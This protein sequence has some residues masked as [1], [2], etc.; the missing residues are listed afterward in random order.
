MMK[1]FEFFLQ[2]RESLENPKENLSS[3]KKLLLIQFLLL[4]SKLLRCKRK[5]LFIKGSELPLMQ[6][7]IFPLPQLLINFYSAMIAQVG[8]AKRCS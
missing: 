7:C 4:S 2:L 1:N 6:F 3:L 8:I 5:R